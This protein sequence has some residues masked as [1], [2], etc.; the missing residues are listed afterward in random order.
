M[1]YIEERGYGESQAVTGNPRC[2]AF[3]CQLCT[4]IRGAVMFNH[5]VCM[6]REGVCS[7]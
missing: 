2:D 4:D 6:L 7:Q 1:L 5:L 3:Y